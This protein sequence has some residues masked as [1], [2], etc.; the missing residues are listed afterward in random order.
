MCQEAGYTRLANVGLDLIIKEN[1]SVTIF[2]PSE[3]HNQKE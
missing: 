1:V 3:L 2:H